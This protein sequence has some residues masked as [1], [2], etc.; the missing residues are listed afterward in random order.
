MKLILKQI[1][2]LIVISCLVF[3]EGMQKI[4]IMGSNNLVTQIYNEGLSSKRLKDLMKPYKSSIISFEKK[5]MR[6]VSI[7]VKYKLQDELNIAKKIFERKSSELGQLNRLI[8]KS[9]LEIIKKVAKIYDEKGLEATL[10]YFKSKAFIDFGTATDKKMKKLSQAALIKANLLALDNQYLAAKQTYKQA[11]NYDYSIDTLS[12]YADFLIKENYIDEAI[13]IKEKLLKEQKVF[14]K[15][16]PSLY[17]FDVAKTLGS[18]GELYVSESAV[19]KAENSLTESLILIR[20]IAKK[21]PFVYNIYIAGTLNNLGNLYLLKEEFI[22]AEAFYNKSLKI[23]KSLNEKQ[24]NLH[25]IALTLRNLA[26]TN[27]NRNQFQKS[28]KKYLESLKIYAD[29]EKIDRYVYDYIK[30]LISFARFYE[31]NNQMIKAEETYSKALRK[32]RKL[33]TRNPKIYSKDLALMIHDLSIFN[34]KIKKVSMA[35]KLY[36]ESFD[37]YSVL[38]KKNSNLHGVSFATSLILGYKFWSK[39]IS[40]IKQA[41][42]ILMNIPK[43]KHVQKML[44]TI[45]DIY[46]EE[47]KLF[48]SSLELKT[49]AD[50]NNL[51]VMYGKDGDYDRALEAYTQA[52]E[53]NAKSYIAYHNIGNIYLIRKDY[54]EADNA[55][56]K[57][58]EFNPDYYMNYFKRGTLFLYQEQYKKAI[59]FFKL[60]LAINSKDI[61]SYNNLSIAYFE[62]GD[63]DNGINT[64]KKILE[65]DPSNDHIRKA[66]EETLEIH[67]K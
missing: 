11:L 28:E 2:F 61:N 48:L 24:S 46:S 64:L 55:Y 37:M 32:L 36:N 50:Y 49:E 13:F 5:I 17:T 29:L 20:I 18:L 60:A 43:D 35:E 59:E 1:V 15:S 6:T 27:S 67:K 58:I 57:S 56:L 4:N 3:S 30:T 25:N 40:Y 8:K 33:R 31:R 16:N 53:V 45:E 10:E 47:H 12:T 14:M 42:D 52:I 23:H 65:V 62:F 22:S 44:D 51:G 54:I 21:N 19:D 7:E 63:V 66:I 39:D 26:I 34:Y 9:N 38:Y 41:K